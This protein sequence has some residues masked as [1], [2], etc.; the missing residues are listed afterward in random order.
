MATEDAKVV[1]DNTMQATVKVS[2]IGCALQNLGTV[3]S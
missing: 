3:T 2:Y 1:T